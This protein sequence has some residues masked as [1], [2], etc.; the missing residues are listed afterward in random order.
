MAWQIPEVDLFEVS[1]DWCEVS[2][3]LFMLMMKLLVIVLPFD[4]LFNPLSLF[5]SI[6]KTY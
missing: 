5:I 1:H 6:L 3:V 2:V 4:C